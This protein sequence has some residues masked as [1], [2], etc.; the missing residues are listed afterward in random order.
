MTG[1]RAK[2]RFASPAGHHQAPFG[3]ARVQRKKWPTPTE[4][5]WRA[6]RRTAEDAGLAR[7][8]PPPPAR[9]GLFRPAGGG[10]R[11][12]FRS[13][14]AKAGAR[15]WPPV[16]GSLSV[17]SSSRSRLRVA[18]AMSRSWS[19][20]D[21]DFR[22]RHLDERR[23][24]DVA[25]VQQ[26]LVPGREAITGMARRVAR[27]R[28]RGH[29]RRNLRLAVR[30]VP[31]GRHRRKARPAPVSASR[32]P[33]RMPVEFAPRQKSASALCTSSRALGKASLPSASS[34]PPT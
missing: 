13:T 1:A 20:I 23:M 15:R 34:A 22:V 5:P 25:D 19:N 21:R 33:F 7:V 9:A 14:L 4:R 31:T 12:P 30:S 27:Q 17:A 32:A 26:L 16:I 3:K 6:A 28:K 24:H 29:A 10:S 11:Y 8:K 2:N 18:R